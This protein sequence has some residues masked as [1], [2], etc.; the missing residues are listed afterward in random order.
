MPTALP[1]QT[2]ISQAS[3][4]ETQYRVIETRYGNGYSQRALDGINGNQATWSVAWENITEAQFDTLVGAFDDAYGVDYFNWT[5]PGDASSKKWLVPKFT[6]SVSS[7]DIYSVSA[8]LVQVF[9]V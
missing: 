5:A 2:S 7:G 4:G 9:D 3:Q 6:R 1:L 8:S